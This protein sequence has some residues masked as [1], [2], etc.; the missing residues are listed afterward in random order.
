MVGVSLV[1]VYDMVSW[2]Q[3]LTSHMASRWE[4]LC[5]SIK[6]WNWDYETHR[7]QGNEER[8]RE[9]E[10]EQ[11]SHDDFRGNIMKVFLKLQLLDLSAVD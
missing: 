4:G 7:T 5:S 3:Q 1:L 2:P 9:R 6:T 10:R 11:L 8:E